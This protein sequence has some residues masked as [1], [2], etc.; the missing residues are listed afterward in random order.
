MT[1][2]GEQY[3]ISF[4][5]YDIFGQKTNFVYDIVLSDTAGVMANEKNILL[6][7]DSFDN[8]SENAFTD[9]YSEMTIAGSSG[10]SAELNDIDETAVLTA[11]LN[12]N[13]T[14]M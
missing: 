14:L 1:S 7:E 5:T 9:T 11:R 12:E 10:F 13:S 3:R 4:D 8:Y 2:E 6:F